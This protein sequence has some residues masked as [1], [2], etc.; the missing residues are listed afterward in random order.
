M[1]ANANRKPQL[2][3]A[4][5]EFSGLSSPPDAATLRAWTKEYPEFARE[6]VAFATDWVAMN[7]ARVERAVTAEDVDVVVN[8]TMSRVQAVLD[9]A[10]MPPSIRARSRLAEES[11]NWARVR[12]EYDEFRRASA[13]LQGE[14]LVNANEL[15]NLHLEIQDRIEEAAAT[16]RFTPD[17][18]M[19]FFAAGHKTCMPAIIR[20]YWEAYGLEPARRPRIAP[21]AAA[22]SRMEEVILE[23]MPSLGREHPKAMKVAW[24][25][26]GMNIPTAKICRELGMVRRTVY[27]HRKLAIE[28]L[29]AY[30]TRVHQRKVA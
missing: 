22:I 3:E 13:K 1:T 19:R 8:R 20:S 18:E 29:A 4:L 16:L 5:D 28:W 17:K 7:A 23:W 14:S 21:S 25:Y 15:V 24:L 27:R 10:A 9:A 6:L 26:F 2:D 12:A 30:I 11:A